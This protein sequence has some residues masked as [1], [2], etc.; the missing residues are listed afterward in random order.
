MPRHT[1]ICEWSDQGSDGGNEVMDADEV[2]VYADTPQ[3]AIGKAKKKWRLTVGSE[4]PTCRLARAFIS[5]PAQRA[6]H[7]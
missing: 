4:W 6:E 1:V 3:A 5:T 2:V 7:A